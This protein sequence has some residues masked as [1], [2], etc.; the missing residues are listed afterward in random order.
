[1]LALNVTMALDHIASVI[2]G[3]TE[4]RALVELLKPVSVR[5]LSGRYDLDN[6]PVFPAPTALRLAFPH[7]RITDTES[8]FH[9][10]SPYL[11]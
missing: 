11:V 8:L 3:H 2:S 10:N 6:Y 5:V 4:A 9:F 1:M 7:H